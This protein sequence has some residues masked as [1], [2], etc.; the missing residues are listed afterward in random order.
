MTGRRAPLLLAAL[1]ATVALGIPTSVGAQTVTTTDAPTTTTTAPPV[2]TAPSTTHPPTTAPPTTQPTTTTTTPGPTTTTIPPTTT[3]LTPPP[4][5]GPAPAPVDVVNE[6]G[7]E[8]SPTPQVVPPRSTPRVLTPT[9]GAV[10]KLVTAEIKSGQSVANGAVADAKA[11][12]RA[13]ADLE[14]RQA[15]LQR[16]YETLHADDA[17]AAERLQ[18]QRAAMRTRAVALYVS[19]GSDPLI[20][21]G[22]NIH[23]YGRKRVLVEALHAADR[24][25]LQ[26]YLAAKSTAG[27]DVNRLVSDLEAL[28]GQVIAARANAEQ[29][30]QRA[31][32]ALGSLEAVQAGAQVAIGGFVF[33]VGTP[34]SFTDTFG[35]PRMVGTPYFHLHQGTDI[36]AA[37][38][39]PL[40]ACERGF[41]FKKGT[42]RLGGTKLWISGES[43]TTYYYAHLSAFA[44][45]LADGQ[46][47]EAGDVVGYVGNTGNAA[48][49]P[50]HLHFEI[51]PGG[52]KAIDPYPTLKTVDDAQQQ[53]GPRVT[54]TTNPGPPPAAAGGAPAP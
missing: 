26:S 17:K 46:V 47:V 11:A 5:S 42:D 49:T 14:A 28:N 16:T 45:G 7:S 6:D 50:S 32:Q 41:I 9:D 38:G 29:A 48:T 8:S 37:Y 25:T 44:D 24:R 21:V 51:H 4:A 15:G 12:D 22:A 40:F 52:G 2:T 31:Q 19:G 33:P 27:E 20:P 3:T 54:P 23:E 53:Y 43:G 30:S 13:L 1:A 36:F 10:T 35:A 34:H 18:S 39:T